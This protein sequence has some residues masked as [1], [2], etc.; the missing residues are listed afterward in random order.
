MESSRKRTRAIDDN[1]DSY[2]HKRCIAPD[3]DFTS[4]EFV[5]DSYV[6]CVFLHT[7]RYAI[8]GS[9]AANA[10]TFLITDPR[11]LKFH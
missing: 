4:Q 8:F 9:L 5:S 7:S 3:S 10:L 1:G 2:G 6:N 11:S